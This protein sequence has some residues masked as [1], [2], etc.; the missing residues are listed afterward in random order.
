M[1]VHLPFCNLTSK[2]SEDPTHPEDQVTLR[3]YVCVC[4]L[5]EFF[6][7][8]GQ[9]CGHFLFHCVA[10]QFVT[11]FLAQVTD[12]NTLLPLLTEQTYQEQYTAC[13]SQPL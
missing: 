10:T 5:K 11:S 1:Q 9:M 4:V 3:V 13:Q 6:L 8:Y 12:A 2:A 7:L